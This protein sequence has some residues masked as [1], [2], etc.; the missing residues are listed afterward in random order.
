M[1]GLLPLFPCLSAP[2]LSGQGNVGP[3]R[4]GIRTIDASNSRTSGQIYK[5][6]DNTWGNFEISDKATVAADAQYGAAVTWDCSSADRVS[7]R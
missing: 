1:P 6:S 2:S 5:D 3:T 7:A 4:G